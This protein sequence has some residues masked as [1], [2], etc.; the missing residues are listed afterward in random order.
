M[1]LREVVLRATLSS[2][3]KEVKYGYEE[4]CG[5]SPKGEERNQ[6]D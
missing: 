1:A 3:S 2:G 6:K 5:C 4:N